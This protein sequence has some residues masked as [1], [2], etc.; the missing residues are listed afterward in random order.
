MHRSLQGATFH[1]EHVTPR[2]RGGTSDWENLALA[3]PA[4]NL[5]KADRLE[6]SNPAGEGTVR[7]FQPRNDRWT[8]HF[9][10]RGYRV[11]G[12]TAVGRATVEALRMNDARRVRIR[13]AEKAF[14]LF[15]P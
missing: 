6:V 7:L 5:H 4:C 8:D 13:R 10:F 14:G 3:C 9:K 11:V 2:S 12:I 1:I 15:P